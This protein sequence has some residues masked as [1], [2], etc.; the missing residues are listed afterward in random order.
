M[1]GLKNKL[2]S[3]QSISAS[4]FLLYIFGNEMKFIVVRFQVYSDPTLWKERTKV[5]KMLLLKW[6][7]DKAGNFAL[8][9]EIFKH[10][11]T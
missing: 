10:L 8:A 5:K 3:I 4:P 11:K 7:P 1:V 9:T 2:D 6:H